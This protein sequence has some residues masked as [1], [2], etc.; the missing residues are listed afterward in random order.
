MSLRSRF[1][2]AFA[3]VGAVVAALVGVLSYQAASDRV[4]A[5]ID[6]TLRSGTVA[7]AHAQAE[8]LALSDAV[9]Q[10]P[11]LFRAGPARPGGRGR[12]A[13]DPAGRGP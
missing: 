9:A 11:D 6:R 1:A 3:A 12:A 10:G 8:E 7:L 13:A 4:L 5:E 2:L